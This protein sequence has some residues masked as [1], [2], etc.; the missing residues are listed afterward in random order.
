MS[1]IAVVARN[2]VTKQSVN[3]ANT[4]RLLRFARKDAWFVLNLRQTVLQYFT[5][6]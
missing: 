4:D 3:A 1:E 5:G 2:E 6:Y